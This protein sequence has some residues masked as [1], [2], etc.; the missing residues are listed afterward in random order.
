MLLASVL[1][2]LDLV[3]LDLYKQGR[4]QSSSELRAAFFSGVRGFGHHF[5]VAQAS[6]MHKIEGA[7]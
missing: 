2:G 7:L 1:L 6:M 3:H 4:G 5:D